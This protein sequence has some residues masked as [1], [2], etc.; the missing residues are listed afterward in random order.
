MRGGGGCGGVGGGILRL[1]LRSVV[2][3][4]ARKSARIVPWEKVTLAHLCE[5]ALTFQLID[6]PP[7]I[8]AGYK[9]PDQIL[10]SV[11]GCYKAATERMLQAVAAK[12][13]HTTP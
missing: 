11:Q 13:I 2:L 5:G 6:E 3:L 1:D 12:V 8:V 4:R 10:S 9:H 7:L